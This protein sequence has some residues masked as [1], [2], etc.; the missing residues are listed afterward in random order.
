MFCNNCGTENADDTAFC[1]GCGTPLQTGQVVSSAMPEN[2]KYKKMGGWLL[3]NVICSFLGIVSG[4]D[5]FATNLD[6][7]QTLTSAGLGGFGAM[8]VVESLLVIAL[9]IVFVVMVFTRKPHFL[10]IY[11][12]Q[13]I[14]SIVISIIGICMVSGSSYAAYF[15]VTSMIGSTVGTIGALIVWT[16]Y[17]CKSVRVRTYMGGTEFIDKAI[18]KFRS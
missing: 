4:V 8:C 6:V 2:P 13:A 11:Q 17:F 18:V 16:L 3:F 7:L 10:L 12:I 5:T 1:S 14:A 15:D 9:N